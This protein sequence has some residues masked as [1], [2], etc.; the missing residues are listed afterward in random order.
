M[1]STLC[2]QSIDIVGDAIHKKTDW[3]IYRV[4]QYI[5]E[6]DY[7]ATRRLADKIMDHLLDKNEDVNNS[8]KVPVM[9]KAIKLRDSLRMDNKK[10]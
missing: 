8:S 6:T 4:M 10:F 7:P 9:I 1:P 2:E 5:F 3:Q